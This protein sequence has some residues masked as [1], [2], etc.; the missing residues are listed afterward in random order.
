VRT[1]T[2]RAG[3]LVRAIGTGGPALHT[4]RRLLVQRSIRASFT[5]RLVA[6]YGQCGSAIRWMSG[7]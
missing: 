7:R 2:W 4:I 5:E 6:A 3:D 1:W